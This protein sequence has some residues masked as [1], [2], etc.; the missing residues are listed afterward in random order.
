MRWISEVRERMRGLLFRAREEAELDEELRFHLD[1]EADRLV[2]EEG[3]DPVEARRRA[4]VA[5]GG[6][7]KHKEEVRDAR[8]LAWLPGSWLDFKLGLR[9]LVKYPGLT[10]V[11][12][13]GMAVAIAIAIGAAVFSGLSTMVDPVLPLDGG[14]R[15]IAIQNIDPAARDQDRATHLHDLAVWRR[16]LR[17][18]EELGAAR[19]VDRNLVTPDGR[20]EP[21]RIAEMTASGFRLAR[22]PPLLGRY[23]YDADERAG[24]APVV[25]IGYDVWRNRFA[26][27]RDVVGRTLQIGAARHTIVGVMPEGFAFPINNRV[28]AP[29]RLDPA[30]YRRGEAPPIDVFGRLAPGATPR[31]VEAQLAGIARRIAA[32]QPAGAQ[33]RPRVLPYARSFLDTPELAWVFYLVQLLVS[34]L[35]VVIAANVAILVYAR[36]A[37]R[38]G[39]IAVRLALGA[40]RARVVTQL[41]AEA[42]VLSLIAAA[43]GLG[44]AW[45]ALRQLAAAVARMGGEEVPFW[46]QIGLSPGTVVYATGLAV[47][48]AVIAGVVPALQATGPRVQSSLRQLGGGT[49][50]QMGRTWTVLIVAQ[51]AVAVAV[52]PVAVALGWK[53]LFP[54]RSGGPGY[55]AEELLAAS[56][57]VDRE[58]P[59]TARALAY[60]Q[61]FAARLA[62]RHTTLAARLEAEPGVSAVSF[63]SHL[64][65][66]EAAAVAEVED[67]RAELARHDVRFAQVDTT[68][69]R[70]FGAGVVVGRAFRA[71]DLAGGATAVV[72]NRSF[73]RQV[74]GGAPAL[75]R[76]FRY[77]RTEDDVEPGGV[78]LGGWYEI[79]G[80]VGDVTASSAAPEDGLPT[81]YHPSAPGRLNPATIVVRVQGT[82]PESFAGRIREIA[83]ALD[84]T[85]RLAGVTPLAQIQRQ[86]ARTQR[87]MTLGVIV[88]TLTVVL[89][90]AAGIHALMSFTVARRR[91]EIGI[92]A[93]LGAHPRRILAS[94]FARALRQLSLGIAVGT[95]IAGALILAGGF[96]PQRAAVL[97][98]VVALLMLA[99]GLLAALGPARQGLRIQPMEALRAE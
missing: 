21:L 25:V 77:A 69:F 95:L 67:R 51:V 37:T 78:A 32:T 20:A 48:A 38:S 42:L 85:L 15:M 63:A 64:P 35:L 44:V 76:R 16:E 1:M 43:A 28:W 34:M 94:I 12:G 75:G 13:L 24:A 96:T 81:L 66:S 91:K 90:S 58:T 52:L 41:F 27:R 45:F 99:V 62:D 71:A 59:T 39:E 73:V 18:V 79:V 84:P 22:V 86:E 56:V 97:L 92:R 93:A 70:V 36:T 88:L 98:L 89:F 29:L 33:L 53:E 23:F 46:W 61:E 8:G 14:D 54:S 83:T 2:R 87:L 31:Q 4:A 5:F 19:T 57:G 11:G 40:S 60:R 26:G 10:L 17:G 68:F 3:L 80:V 30:D 50:M 9:M 47:L 65:G 49:G 55:A 72:A 74:L 6:V 7:E 82:T